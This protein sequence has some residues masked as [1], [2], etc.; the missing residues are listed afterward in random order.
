MSRINE[1]YK[2]VFLPVT[3]LIQS[4]QTR[5]YTCTDVTRRSAADSDRKLPQPIMLRGYRGTRLGALFNR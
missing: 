2:F 3:N 4:N 1:N 5:C